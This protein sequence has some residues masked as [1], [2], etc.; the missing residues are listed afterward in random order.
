MQE[1]ERREGIRLD[2]ANIEPNAG[3]RC[4]GK[5]MLNSFWG[6]LI[7]WRRPTLQTEMFAGKFGQRDN[8]SQTKRSTDPAELFEALNDPEKDVTGVHLVNEN[9]VQFQWVMKEE[10]VDTCPSANHILAAFTTAIARL[11]LYSF[12]ELLGRRVLYFDTG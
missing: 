8:L 3:L 1:F 2:P 12:L 5:M 11:K 6:P 9:L 4:L 7:F 10:F